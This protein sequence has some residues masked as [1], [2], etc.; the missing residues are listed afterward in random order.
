MKR[1]RFPDRRWQGRNALLTVCA[2]MLVGCGTA[3]DDPLVS[4]ASTLASNVVG[5]G[6]AEAPQT[7][8]SSALT[9][10]LVAQIG[11]PLLAVEYLRLDATELY[12]RVGT[13]RGVET[14]RSPGDRGLTI[15]QDG[16]LTATRGFGF[17]LM[18]SDAAE[19]ASVLSRR[20][21][22]HVDRVMLHLDGEYQERAQTHLCRITNEGRDSIL[23]LGRSYAATRFT[24]VCETGNGTYENRYWLDD[25][26]TVRRSIQW[27]SPEIGQLQIDRLT[28]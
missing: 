19:T 5:R 10:E 18:S 22:G 1:M 26:G 2:S 17:D 11:Q 4:L 28:D 3:Q 25:R 16:L 27:V 21:E 20:A 13:N 15:R 7:D 12:T 23:M 14:W 24:E 9:P 8:A 6:G